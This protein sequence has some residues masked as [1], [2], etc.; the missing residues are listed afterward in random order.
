MGGINITDA[1]ALFT[2]KIVARVSDFVK[3]TSFLRSFFKETEEYTKEI[4]IQ[5]QRGIERIAVDVTRGTEGNRN[6]WGTTTEKIFEPPYFREWFDVTELA[7]YDALYANP[8]DIQPSIFERFIMEAAEKTSIMQDTIDRAYE[9]LCGQ[10]LA[11]GILTL[12][13]ATNIDF[14]RQAG[15]MVNLTGAYW[16]TGGVDPNTSITAGCRWL[17]AEGKA[18][19]G[20]FNLIMGETAF[21]DFMANAK[22][23]ARGAIYNWSMENLLPATRNSVGGVFHGSVS[24]D[25]YRV[26]LWTYPERYT[27]ADGNDHKYVDDKHAILIPENPKFVLAY[28]AVPQLLSTGIQPV[29]GKFMVSRYVDDRAPKEI[30][31]VK[32]AGVPIPTLVDQIYTMQVVA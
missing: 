29:K 6:T 20:V 16:A 25:S 1:Q 4:S 13:K 31:D 9:K 14:K 10:V 17:R 19:G 32:S 24:M 28:A 21:R 11:T 18:I 3:P 2:K 12:N 8:N 22:V 23:Q 27:D 5:V 26:N 7:A 15:S 30:I